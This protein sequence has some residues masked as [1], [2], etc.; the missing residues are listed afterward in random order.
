MCPVG[1]GRIM[2]CF[3]DGA[4][5]VAPGA[6]GVR[7]AQALGDH[8]SVGASELDLHVAV[9]VATGHCG[10]DASTVGSEALAAVRSRTLA[11]TGTSPTLVLSSLTAAGKAPIALARRRVQPVLSLVGAGGHDAPAMA[12]QVQ[13]S[14]IDLLIVG[15]PPAPGDQYSAAVEGVLAVTARTGIEPDILG[16]SEPAAAVARCREQMPDVVVV[17]LRPPAP[18]SL[19]GDHQTCTPWEAWSQLCRELV[20]ADV[21]VWAVGVGAPVAAVAACVKEGA[22]GILDLWDLAD[23]LEKLDAN[24]QSRRLVRGNDGGRAEIRVT[25]PGLPPPYDALI[26][27]TPGEHRVLHQM[28]HGASAGEIAKQLVVSLATV[29]SHIRSILRK[30]GVS[31]QLAAVALANGTHANPFEEGL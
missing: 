7:L 28:M 8:L 10:V 9:G 23:E 16:S 11:P 18:F 24:L 15:P 31:S 19:N 3:G 13:R 27:L 5:Q 20:H 14:D 25:R 30:L 4:H 17:P 22:N 21:P 26:D 2:V 12:G 6:L 1:A 29:R